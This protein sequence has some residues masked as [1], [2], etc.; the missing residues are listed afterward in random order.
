MHLNIMATDLPADTEADLHSLLRYLRELSEPQRVLLSQVCKV[1]SL[2]LVMPATNAV[3]ERSFSCL[4]CL[5][6]IPEGYYDSK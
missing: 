1:V 3:S 6:D 5:K 2:I 4:R